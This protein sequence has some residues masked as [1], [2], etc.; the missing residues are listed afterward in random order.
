M[1]SAVPNNSGINTYMLRLAEVYLNYAEA[2]L[3]NSESTTDTDALKYFN[4]VRKRAGMPEKSKISYEDLRHENRVE[5]AFEGLYWYYLVRRSY[6]QQQEVVNYCNHQN[7]N[8][9]YFEKQH[10]HIQTSKEYVA[11]GAGVATATAKSL[12]LPMA[13]TDQTKNPNLKTDARRQHQDYEGMRLVS[14]KLT[15]LPSS[16][17]TYLSQREN[18]VLTLPKHIIN[19]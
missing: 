7:R 14:V 15:K 12:T 3:G 17:K 4:A 9:S 1:A 13:D 6:Y 19:R 8:A 11:P 2:I 18:I 10:Q 5:F 16:T